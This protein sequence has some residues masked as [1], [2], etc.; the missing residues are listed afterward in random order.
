MFNLKYIQVKHISVT[1]STLLTL[2]ATMP[3]CQSGHDQKARDL[4]K[5]PNIIVIMSDD[6]GY[7]DIGCYGG[8]I[9]TPNLD[10]LAEN[11]IRMTQ[12]YNAA[13]CC[14]TRAS[15]LTGLYPHQAGIGW[16]TGVDIESSIPAYHG[17]LSFNAVTLAEVAR[18]AGYSTFAVG[19]WHVS[20]NVRDEGPKHNWPLQRGF[21]RYYGTIQGA[22][23]FWDPATLCRDNT[24]I[25]PFNDPE[26]DA[27]GYYYTDALSDEASRF[28]G[29]RDKN[30]PF[31]LYVSHTAAH[32]PMHARPEDIQ[33]YK[34]MY[35]GGYEKIRDKRYR[36]MQEMNLIDTSVELTPPD[37]M[38]WA[39]GINKQVEAERMEIYA[40]M[41]DV[42]DEGIGRIVDRLK[43]ENIF[44][45]TIIIYLQDNGA[46]AEEIG[47]RGRTRPVAP[48]VTVLRALAPDEPE[49]MIIPRITREGKI[50]MHG[51]GIAG[52]PDTTY[53]AYG[54]SWANVSNTPFREYKHW[55]HEG[56]IATPLIIHC[57]KM[58]RKPGRLS[59]FPGHLIDIMPTLVELTGAEFPEN[60][61]GYEITPPEGVSL[62]PLFS[63][64]RSERQQLIFW[65]HEMNRAL[66]SG[67]WKLV[68]KGQLLNGGYGQW[69]NYSTGKWELYNL[70]L[71]RAE[72][73]DLSETYPDKVKELTALWEV[74]A[75]RTGVFPTPWTAT[76]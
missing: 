36:R 30:K 50:V 3:S 16:M 67:D 10:K 41:V 55:V 25:T 19:K 20:K 53:V 27:Q 47:T 70:K 56:G 69:K 1:F 66:R 62:V 52:G 12:F 42:M 34:G 17:D 44:E 21:D 39:D 75:R 76:D 14:P 45:N 58:I 71:D 72:M 18:S 43:E 49:Y 74:H 11:G 38:P 65:E 64:E 4:S 60:F 22:G 8:E 37:F 51:E 24:L 63:K 26:Y 9:R 15:L 7:S 29:E 33:K 32:W 6:M 13:R 35:D 73:H 61:G 46:C 28:I 2:T 5:R 59:S 48:D 57:P 68:S 40:A 23:S 31:F 54:K